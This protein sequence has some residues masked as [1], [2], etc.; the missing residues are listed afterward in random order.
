ML[1]CM[2]VA[3]EADAS[4]HQ[5]IG[6]CLVRAFYS[7]SF[8]GT[9]LVAATASAHYV[10]PRASLLVLVPPWRARALQATCAIGEGDCARHAPSILSLRPMLRCMLV[11]SEADARTHQ[12]IGWCVVRAF[13]SPFGCRGF[14]V[15]RVCA[16][17]ILLIAWARQPFHDAFVGERPRL[18]GQG[19]S[20][21]QCEGNCRTK[22]S[23]FSPVGT[24]AHT[25]GSA[26]TRPA[27][28]PPT[29]PATA[30]HATRPATRPAAT[31][32][33]PRPAARPAAAA[34][35]YACRS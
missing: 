35:P 9:Q 8:F 23:R 34:P 13:Y 21:A 28:R 2:L 17:R 1:R 11:A 14:L 10:G 29:T 5:G 7:Q 16:Q 20:A 4:T 15:A 31:P 6:W 30:A 27:T 3:S 25:S 18:E 24:P 22:G 26:A 32:A 33:A 12:G 19:T